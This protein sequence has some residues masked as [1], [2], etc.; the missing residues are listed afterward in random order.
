[1]TGQISVLDRVQDAL[2]AAT[3]YEAR[4]EAADWRC[5]AHEDS[6]PSLSVAN[7][8]GKVL[9]KCQA[10]CPTEDVLAAIGL[11]M[12]DLFDPSPNGQEGSRSKV[13]GT[14]DYTD[15]E[16][17][18]LFQVVRR[19]RPDGKKEFLQRRPDGHGGWIW[20]LGDTR[21][22]LF[23][24]PDVLGAVREGVPV[25]VVEG[26][27][28]ALALGRVG[29]VATCNPGGAGKWR[30]EFAQVLHGADVVL[31]PDQDPPGAKHAADV[32]ASLVGVAGSV[33]VVRPAVG[34]DAADHLGAGYGVED[35]VPVD[36]DVGTTAPIDVDG[37]FINWQS[38]WAKDRREADWLFEEVLAR[39]RGHSIFAG[40][41]LGK[42]LFMLAVALYL[43]GRGV[44]VVYLD[45]EMGEDDLY[46]RLADMGHGPD[47]DLSRLHYA[48][49]PSLPPLDEQEG[50]KA[51]LATVDAVQD[52]HPGVHVA[53]VI[54]TTARAVAGEENSADTYRNFYRWTGIG[55]KQRGATWARLDHAGKD[56][57]KGQ[58]GSSS[59]GDD[60]DVV[61]RLVRTDNGL[62]LRREATRMG[63]VPERVAFRQMEAP[64]RFVRVAEDWPAGTAEVAAQLE[65]LGVAPSVGGRAAAQALRDA[66]V[67]R[68]NTLV[69]AAQ[70]W[71]RVK[72]EEG[73]K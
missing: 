29:C 49:L 39:G 15:E 60:V 70:K 72:A 57:T 16:G 69:W 20:K 63:W 3:G 38:F 18:L 2:R 26:E 43:I 28:D 64:L 32:E 14:Y 7:G 71:R 56:A 50:A 1:M 9:L 37:L 19:V 4:G 58:R 46:D 66:D 27:K 24:L 6:S 12:A 68:A 48:L 65:A 13:V 59:K 44:A 22:T 25:Y 10:G 35:F 61:W 30:A 73:V 54:D 36:G 40:H 33:R 47:T 41:K 5:P 11:T 62:E 67:G 52:L 23:Q 8:G 21:R 55:L 17:R 53:V 34:K 31:V 42:S 45:Y 51:L